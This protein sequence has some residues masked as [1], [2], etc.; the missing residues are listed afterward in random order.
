MRM[1]RRGRAVGAALVVAVAVALSGCSF[2]GDITEG[3]RITTERLGVADALR[4]LT[5]KLKGL[6]QVS[7]ASYAFDAL[8][9]STTPSLQV[10]LTTLDTAGWE[11]VVATIDAAA[12]EDALV[13]SPIAVSITSGSSPGSAA[14]SVSAS[15]DTQYGGD[16]LLGGALDTASQA[17]AA[18]P[19]ALINL[20]SASDSAAAVAVGIPD[21]AEQLLERSATDASVAQLAEDARST[22]QWLMLSADG[23][24]VSGAPPETLVAWASGVLADGLPRYPNA[25][26]FDES[27]LSARTMTLSIADTPSPGSVTAMWR[28]DAAPGE[29]EEWN[30]FTAALLAAVPLATPGSGCMPFQLSYSWPGLGQAANLFTGCGADVGTASSGNPDREALTTFRAA[31]AASGIDLGTLGFTLS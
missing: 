23:L 30:S 12:A 28:S 22:G 27:T 2:I 4:V 9:V 19:G 7:S 11:E 1:S 21:T 14:G 8:D 17:L 20:S 31:L 6:E 15:F 18:F 5:D 16:W 3:Q 26:D 24:D 10:E 13:G 25:L 29:G